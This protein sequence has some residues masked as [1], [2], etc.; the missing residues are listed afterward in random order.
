MA[1]KQFDAGAGMAKTKPA[2][3]NCFEP[4]VC[5][6]RRSHNSRLKFARDSTESA[7]GIIIGIEQNTSK[8]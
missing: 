8:P 3:G 4:T 2:N 6:F 1:V 7:A 5:G